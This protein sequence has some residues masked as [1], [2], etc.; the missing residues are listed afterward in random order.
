MAQHSEI[1]LEI[2]D[3]PFYVVVGARGEEPRIL[4]E[5]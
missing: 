2:H 4:T 5:R 3:G 1:D